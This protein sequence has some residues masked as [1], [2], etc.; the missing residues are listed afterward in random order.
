[1]GVTRL[2]DY[3]LGT[4]ASVALVSI[5]PEAA[6]AVLPALGDRLNHSPFPDVRCRAAE[7]L[8]RMGARARE[9]TPALLEALESEFAEVRS[10]AAEA[11]RKVDPE[12]ARKAGIE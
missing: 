7:A 4:N 6:K 11:L 1:M 8:G 10:L 5:D 9:A 3:D 12:A 2:R